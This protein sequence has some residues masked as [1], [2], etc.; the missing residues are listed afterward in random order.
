MESNSRLAQEATLKEY[1]PPCISRT[2]CIQQHID[3]FQEHLKAKYCTYYKSCSSHSMEY[4]RP[5]I[6]HKS[7]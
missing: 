3:S 1:I 5:H 4:T 7:Q 6:Q 2:D